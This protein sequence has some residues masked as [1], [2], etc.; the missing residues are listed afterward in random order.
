MVSD[1]VPGNG[2]LVP[3]TNGEPDALLDFATEPA[4][5]GAD[6]LHGAGTPVNNDLATEIVA[7]AHET[8]SQSRMGAGGEFRER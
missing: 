2:V 8:C 1:G 3:L 7:L 5:V 4:V 6:A